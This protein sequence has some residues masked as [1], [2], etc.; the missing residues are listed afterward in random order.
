[1]MEESEMDL[2]L[3]GKRAL[4]TASTGGIGLATAEAFLREGASVVVNGRDKDRLAQ[5]LHSLR[6]R[7]GEDRVDGLPG[8]MS[9]ERDL[10]RLCGEIGERYGRI[11]CLMA[12]L[13]TGK[14]VADDKLDRNEWE[15]MIRMNLYSAVDLLR[16]GRKLFSKDGGSV[17]LM[18]SLAAVQRIAAPPAYAAAKAGVS[19]LVSYLAPSFAK[20]NIRING[21]APGNIFFP[22]G[23]WEELLAA[24]EEGVKSYIETDVPM[25]RFGTPEEIADFV[26]FLSSG[27]AGFITGAV[28]SVDGGQ[29]T[30]LR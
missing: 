29:S 28:V 22:G 10:E 27:R 1:M 8:D 7:Y 30:A 12:N 18:S 14:P 9:Q 17:V 6:Q 13:G 3:E 21:V 24:D 20:E 19:S 15:H 26:V 16:Y 2:G 5:V 23:R 4:L 11:H 25:K